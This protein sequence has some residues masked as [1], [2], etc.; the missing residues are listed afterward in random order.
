MAMAGAYITYSELFDRSPSR[1]EI[2]EILKNLPM[3]NA[4]IALI[5]MNMA[6]RF[7]FQEPDRPNF[8]RLQQM[9]MDGFLNDETFQRLKERFA[10]VSPEDRPLFVPMTV[11]NVL[12]MVLAV[13]RE[14][15]PLTGEDLPSLRFALGTACLMMNNL[16]LS[17]D[18]EQQIKE[19]DKEKRRLA[20][21]VQALAPFELA[22]PPRA[23]HLL[24]RHGVLF[25]MLLNTPSVRCRISERCRGFDF[26][27]EFEK[28]AGI[29]LKKW[30]HVVFAIYSYYL[31]GS[32]PLSPKPEFFFIDPSIFAGR[33]RVTPAESDAVLK[34]LWRSLNQSRQELQGEA[35]TDTRF[36][37]VPFRSYPLIELSTARLACVDISFILEKL[38]TG[39]HWVMHDAYTE[40]SKRDDLFKAWG[41]LFEEYVHWLLSGMKTS[42]PVTYFKPQWES[43]QECVD[44][45]LLQGD[46]LVA[47]EYKGGFL[48]RT[49]RYSGKAG[50]FISDVDKKFGQGCHQLAWKL[51]ALFSV[52]E[53]EHQRMVDGPPLKE[54][55]AVLPVLVLQDHILRVPFLNWYLNRKFQAELKQHTLRPDV[56]IRPLNVVNISELE[57][58][59]N[60]CAASGFDLVYALHHRAVRDEEMLSDLQEF[61]MQFPN[62]GREQSERWKTVYE[63]VKERLFGYLFGITQDGA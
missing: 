21:L 35:R 55:R 49:A 51:N 32:N 58:M 38:Q 43:G 4:A 57:T 18:E 42:L 20:L 19:G 53:F 12:R 31:E 44:G 40:R 17:P 36:D 23:H 37:F 62:Y 25:A 47:L 10:S 46:V 28:L 5:R 14:E 27:A 9:F 15:E 3:R 59:V 7:V 22:N 60:S 41:I 26:E 1:D 11:L 16:L 30:F 2:I 39:V 56:V 63:E 50:E 33:T 13:S 52:D 48:A 45:M 24:F 29:G 8:R 61:L 6:L 54:I 34:T